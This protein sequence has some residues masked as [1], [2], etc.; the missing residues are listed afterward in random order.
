[1]R[2]ERLEKETIEHLVSIVQGSLSAVMEAIYA[3]GDLKLDLDD[4]AMITGDKRW[5]EASWEVDRIVGKLKKI[6]KR[7]EELEEGM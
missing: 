6:K 2:R 1:M 3:L 4:I 7:L 5:E